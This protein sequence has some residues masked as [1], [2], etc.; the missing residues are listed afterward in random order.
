MT[1]VEAGFSGNNGTCKLNI[2]S[3]DDDNDAQVRS[4]PIAKCPE[5][6][7]GAACELLNS[8][9]SR[10]RFPKF[11]MDKDGDITVQYDIPLKV[12]DDALGDIAMELLIRISHIADEAYPEIMRFIWGS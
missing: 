1:V 10:F 3:S 12:P 6:K 2:I 7:R 9:N 4:A 8:L 11:V 5:D